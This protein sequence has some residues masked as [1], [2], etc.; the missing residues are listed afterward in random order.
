MI[1][2]SVA[3]WS[4]GQPNVNKVNF[5]DFK[6]NEKS[7]N[8]ISR[9]YRERLKLL[10]KK[11]QFVIWSKFIVRSSYLAAQFVFILLKLQQTYWHAFAG[12]AE[13]LT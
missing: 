5:F 9:W 6:V 1:C 8:Q 10:G 7:I 13:I 12:L 4:I 3:L 2:V 11:I